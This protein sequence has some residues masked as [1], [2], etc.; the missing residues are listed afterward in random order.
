MTFRGSI[1]VWIA[2]FLFVAA[3]ANAEGAGA[4]SGDN[5]NVYQYAIDHPVDDA[6]LSLPPTLGESVP[7]T[8]MLQVSDGNEAYAYFYYAGQPVIVDLN[9]RSVVRVG[10]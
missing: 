7:Q 9:T 2:S 6:P 10:Q 4:R 5:V 8:V 1:S 3:S